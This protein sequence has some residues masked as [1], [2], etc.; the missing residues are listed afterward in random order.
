MESA[1]TGIDV[2][3]RVIRERCHKITELTV[4]TNPYPNHK[5]PPDQPSIDTHAPVVAFGAHDD[6]ERRR[7]KQEQLNA[8]HCLS[9]LLVGEITKGDLADQRPGESNDTVVVWLVSRHPV[10]CGKH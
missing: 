2:G 3:R 1:R 6:T 8:V 5:S 10:R 4:G 7:N 9:A